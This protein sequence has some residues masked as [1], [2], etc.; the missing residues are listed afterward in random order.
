MKKN[1]LIISHGAALGGSPIS[2][3]NIARFI[4]KTLFEPIFVFG[5]DGKIVDI[6]KKEGYKTYVIKKRGFLS[7]PVIL[8]FLKILKKEK[9]DLIHLNTLTSYYKYP[10]ISAKI[11]KLPVVWFVRENPEEKRCVK[12][13]RYLN[14]LSDKIV[15]VS[16]DTANH[17]YYANSDK[18]MTIH[19]GID[20][21]NFNND[22]NINKA[23]KKLNLNPKF[24]YISTIASLEKR[25][26]ILEIIDAFNL[27]KND[28]TNL[29]LLIVGK[30][31]TQSQKYLK[32]IKQKIQELNLSNKIILLGESIFIKEIMQIS[33]VFLL[34]SYWEGLSRVLLE[35]MACSKAIVC[36][37]RGG[38][39][40]Q[41]INDFNG[42]AILNK[43]IN[44]FALGIKSILN[45]KDKLI[46]FGQNSRRLSEEKFD[47]KNTTKHIEKL[48]LDVLSKL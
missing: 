19:N 9:I 42:Y 41:V 3:L 32:E 4:D 10:A 18:L 6:A 43:D 39:K 27:I 46:K 13:K 26:G 22:V 29:K 28:F 44:A 7:I 23:Y 20:L 1:I 37:D 36:T 34:F 2:A 24:Q 38:N 8:D 30:D 33:S 21:D 25:K 17:I 40:E 47:I 11:L 12:L 5:E 48:Y 45:D 14:I 15:T 31:R 35:A 16:Y